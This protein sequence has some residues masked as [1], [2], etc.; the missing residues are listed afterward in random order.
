MG[1]AETR[2]GVK[3]EPFS[4]DKAIFRVFGPGFSAAAH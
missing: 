2:K 1:Y 4:R 3:N